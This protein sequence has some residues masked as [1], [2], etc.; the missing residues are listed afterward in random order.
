MKERP[1]LFSGPMVRAIL[2]GRKTQT[3]RVMKHQPPDDVAPI[4]AARYHPTIVDR[5]GDE[6]PGPEIFGAFSDDGDWGCKSPFGEPGDR[7]WVRETHLAWWKLDE[8]NPAGPRVFSHVA[9]YAADGYELEPGERWIPSI[10]MLRAASR[11]TLEITDVRAERLQEISEADALAEGSEA[12]CIT[13]RDD[14]D[15]KPHLIKSLGGP[16]RD[17]YR[18]LWEQINGAGSWDANPWV[19]AIEFRRIER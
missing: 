10:H 11:I 9:A 8:A 2:E 7:L 6:A 5:H 12:I 4:T 3:R 1:I 13:F 15:G 16:Y 17:G 18:I 14:A 19:W